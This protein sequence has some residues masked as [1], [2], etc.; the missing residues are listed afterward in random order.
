LIAG[1]RGTLGRALERVCHTRG[2]VA[3]ALGREGLDLTRPASV[4]QAL[5]AHRPWAVVNAAGYVRVD[6]AEADEARCFAENATG[7]AQL[8]AACARRGLPLLTFSSDLVFDGQQAEPYTE[9]S[10]P[11]PLNAYGRSKLAGEQQVLAAHPQALVVR[12]SAFFSGWDEHNFVHFALQAA[13]RGERFEAAED[14]RIAPTYVPDLVNTALD[15]LLDEAA[16]V[17]HV[18]NRGACT[19]AELAYAAVRKAGLPDAFIVP[20]P[21]A[22]LGLAAPRPQQSVLT[23]EKGM[24]LPAL[25][26]ALERCLLEMGIGVVQE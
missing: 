16:G 6:Q 8:A 10:V 9:S 17:W 1:A 11:N 5:E 25:D 12:T 18:A 24:I 13:R 21:L 20:R 2:L 4:E 3:V 14:A 15:L 26:D 19:W 23:S 7:P 22:E